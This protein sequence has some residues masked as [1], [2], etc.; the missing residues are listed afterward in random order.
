MKEGR[1]LMDQI[2]KETIDVLA[3]LIRHKMIHWQWDKIIDNID[4]EMWNNE[5]VFEALTIPVR[6]KCEE[7]SQT[8][9]YYVITMGGLKFL[10]IK[11]PMKNIVKVYYPTNAGADLRT[12]KPFIEFSEE[13]L[14]EMSRE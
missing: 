11:D 6:Y 14:E 8:E 2:S 4:K 1:V 13:A 3:R 9:Y 12:E 5:Q 7:K 10:I